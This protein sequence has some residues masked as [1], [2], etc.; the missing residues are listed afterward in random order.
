MCARILGERR[1][2]H[3]RAR[4]EKWSG[5]FIKRRHCSY[6]RALDKFLRSRLADDSNS[7][8]SAFSVSG[9]SS[10]ICHSHYYSAGDSGFVRGVFIAQEGSSPAEMRAYQQQVK[11]KAEGGSEHRSIFYA[12]RILQPHCF[13]ASID[14]WFSQTPEPAATN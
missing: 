12:G 5:D 3:K 6:G 1:A 10:L 11:P 14:L 7:S 13:I 2:G 9:F 8:S 4:M